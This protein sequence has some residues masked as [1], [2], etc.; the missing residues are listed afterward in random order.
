MKHLTLA[1]AAALGLAAAPIAAQAATL[2]TFGQS[3]GLNTITA[4]ANATGTTF[5]GTGIAV[6]ISQIDAPAVTPIPAFLTLS[7]TSTAAGATVIPSVPPAPNGI[8]EHFTG[9]FSVTS[10]AGGGGT[11]YLSGTFADAAITATGSSAIAVFAPT[12]TFTSSVITDLSPPRSL[13]LALTNVTPVAG[14]VPAAGTTSGL[15]LGPFTASIAGNASAFAVPEPAS[16][17]LLGVGLLGLGLVARR[18]HH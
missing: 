3:S 5:S 17:A 1:A 14:T 7:A 13:S 11:N 6:S 15:T 16:L 9:T 2:L 4:T 8:V 12:T 10:L 18:K